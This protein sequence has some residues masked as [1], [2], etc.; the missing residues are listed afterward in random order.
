MPEETSQLIDTTRSRHHPPRLLCVWQLLAALVLFALLAKM[1]NEGKL[2][3]II[4]MEGVSHHSNEK[5]NKKET[6]QHVK[7]TKKSDKKIEPIHLACEKGTYS[8]RTLQLAYELPFI[9]LFA[10]TLGQT[11]FEASSVVIHDDSAYAV[12]DSSWSLSKFRTDLQPFSPDNVQIVSTKVHKKHKDESGYEALFYDAGFFY[13]V[14][15][16]IRQRD[17]SFHAEIEQLL[18]QDQQYSVVK[19]QMTEFEFEGD[20]KG[21]EGAIAIHDHSDNEAL[22]ILALC[23]A[24]HCSEELKDDVGNGKLVAMKSNGT[25]WTTLRIIDVPPSA[26]FHDYSAISILGDRVAITSQEES[27]V[28]IGRL[29]GLVEGRLWDIDAIEF[30]VDE[31]TVYDFPKDHECQTIYCNIE[32]IHWMNEYTLLAVSDK[33]KGRGKQDFRCFDKDQTAHVFVLP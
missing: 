1:G 17:K 25:V 9:A 18:V 12:C 23:E 24:N 11:K 6:K 30:D 15:E 7:A 8:E 28:W 4:P 22:V 19:K 20:S 13:V 14:R 27:Q 32:G 5:R 29:K 31:G 2:E 21:F 3:S 33:M 16:S 26:A 10:D